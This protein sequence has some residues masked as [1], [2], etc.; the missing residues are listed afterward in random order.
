MNNWGTS[1][2]PIQTHATEDADGHGVR[3]LE[4][5]GPATPNRSV[6]YLFIWSFLIDRF[7]PMVRATIILVRNYDE[8]P[9]C[10]CG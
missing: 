8:H 3:F 5:F 4:R 7:A 10:R 2:K 1:T 6:I 9:P